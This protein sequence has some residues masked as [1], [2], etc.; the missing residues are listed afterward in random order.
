MARIATSRTNNRVEKL[1]ISST[2]FLTFSQEV[3]CQTADG[4]KQRRAG[5]ANPPILFITFL[6]ISLRH[7]RAMLSGFPR[8]GDPFDVFI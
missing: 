7:V 8:R 5:G 1:S 4:G 3:A 6:P 2:S